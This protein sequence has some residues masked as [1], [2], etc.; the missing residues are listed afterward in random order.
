MSST[1][2]VT[3]SPPDSQMIKTLFFER[4]KVWR[5][6]EGCEMKP[7]ISICELGRKPGL[8]DR[9]RRINLDLQTLSEDRCA[10]SRNH[11]ELC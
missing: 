8:P 1:Q 11:S 2:S 5:C 4:A 7:E 6:S 3:I 9:W 10:G